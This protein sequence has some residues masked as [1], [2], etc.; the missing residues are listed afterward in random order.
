MTE[1]QREKL[2]KYVEKRGVSKAAAD[3]GI[4][5]NTLANALAELKVHPGSMSMIDRFLAGLR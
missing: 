3:I 5:R 2:M 1:K 4:A